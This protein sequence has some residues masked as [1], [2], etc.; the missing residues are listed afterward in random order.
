[1]LHNTNEKETSERAMVGLK[2]VKKKPLKNDTLND[3]EAKDVV[4]VDVASKTLIC[5]M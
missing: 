1:M 4:F 3:D 5:S 2:N